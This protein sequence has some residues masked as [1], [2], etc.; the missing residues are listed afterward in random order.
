VTPLTAAR[1][2]ALVLLALTLWLLLTA[3]T[4]DDRNDDTKETTG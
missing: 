4:G 2:A 1:L 3:A